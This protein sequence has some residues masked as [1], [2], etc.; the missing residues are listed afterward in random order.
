MK[1]QWK[2]RTSLFARMSLLFGLLVTFPLVISG[3]VLSLAGWNSVYESGDD[4]A[5]VGTQAVEQSAQQFQRKAESKMREAGSKVALMG[6]ARLEKTSKAAVEAGK[7]A[8]VTNA[9]KMTTRG[10]QAVTKA[11]GSVVRAG[12][13]GLRQSLATLG[14]TNRESLDMLAKHFREQMDG[15]LR[16]S[17]TSV[18]EGLATSSGR[19]WELSADRR[20]T[21]VQDMGIRLQNQILI[22]LQ[23]PLAMNAITKV[24]PD[25]SPRI[26]ETY[27]R[28]NESS[29]VRVVL[30]DY[31][32][33]E[34]ARVPQTDL[35]ASDDPVEWTK[36]DTRE[37][38]TWDAAQAS[39]FPVYVE[40]AQYD[41]RNKVWIRRLVHKFARPSSGESASVL[42][43]M[44]AIDPAMPQSMPLL[45]VDFKLDSLV[46]DAISQELPEGMDV[47]VIQ[48]ENGKIVSCRDTKQINTTAKGILEELP[49]VKDAPL[50]KEKSK[51]FSINGPQGKILGRARYWADYH[52][53]VV[54]TQPEAIVQ[55]PVSELET[56]IR[57]AWQ[58]S[59][60]KV[61][62][63]SDAYITDRLQ[64][65]AKEA[66]ENLLRKGA[67][68]IR[69]QEAKERE[70][71]A[72]DLKKY[73]TELV[74]GLDAQSA[75]RLKKLQTDAGKGMEDEAS[76]LATEAFKEVKGASDMWTARSK[77][78]IQE[79]S[80]Q[81][82]NRAAGKML[83]Y[84]AWLIPLFLVLALF[85][86][87]MTARS[88]VR[89][90]NLLVKGTQ[91]LAAGDYSRRIKIQGGDDELARL[92]VAFNDMAGAIE[93]GQ[94]QLQQSHDFL[95][96]EKARIQGIVES[97]PDGLVM[98]EPTG[99]V[100]FMNPAAI[101]F[102]ELSPEDIPA[103]PF[104]VAH[105]PASAAQR[106]QECM[107]RAQG[108]EG[109]QEYEW[110]E[111]QRRVLQLREV[112]L[113][114]ESGRSYG[115]LLHIHDITR[116]RVIDEMKSDFISLV[117]HELRTPLTSILG[118]S[119]YMLTGR[120]G[121]V[122]DTQK[123]ALES[124]HR[125]AKRLSA[126]ISDFLDVSRIESGKIEMKKEPVQVKSIASRVVEDLRPQASEKQ[127]QVSA[128]I[129]EGSLPLV[130]LGDEQRIA[131]VFT[132]LIGNAL[133]FTEP[134]G[135]IDVSL[136]RQNGEV[137]CKVRDTGCGIPPDELD[138]VFDRFYQVEKVVTR[139]SGGTGLGL[140]IVKNIVEAHGGRIWIESRLGEGTE[141]SFT[142]PGSD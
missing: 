13:D 7:S 14:Q 21:A 43:E 105:L 33:T 42:P 8:F 112:K 102:L 55:Q 94:A 61:K 27:I 58:S 1:F 101:R 49:A 118:F 130:A 133:K 88:L 5:G 9:E 125:Q 82:A 50:F 25:A 22:K 75:P 67:E 120:L 129:E 71:V 46:Q 73:Q 39:P 24:D 57:N 30:V 6:Q 64:Q 3:I 122:A 26:L 76:R 78:E 16:A 138:R 59:L 17:A 44:A 92:A 56:G 84:S 70:Q 114:A 126:I 2:T 63:D 132:N 97:S 107:E 12:E 20:L 115:R 142:L 54:V 136:N 111:P 4:V 77:R 106:V 104:E 32:G 40:P 139:K 137:V 74:N 81:V 47:Q 65:R 36:K 18:R 99:Q 15:E 103:A 83:S 87:T 109:V 100:A 140:A 48:E 69:A 23:Y 128:R 41:E 123:T 62:T 96:T 38:L 51:P 91:A 80:K 85:L 52:C 119:S 108:H 45:V 68:Q 113:R 11:T 72:L 35:P 37:R 124:I 121:A 117:S 116:E 79:K 141:V 10:Q 31:T 90:I 34:A 29:I 60:D 89:P 19:S 131:Q 66:R 98:L 110:Q 95:A 53:W 127:V 134:N 86:A 93:T 135:A 28:K